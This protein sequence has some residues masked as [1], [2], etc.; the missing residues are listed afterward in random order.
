MKRVTL[1]AVCAATVAL[2]AAGCGSSTPQSSG[3]GGAPGGAKPASASPACAGSSTP[4]SVSGGGTLT[5]WLM[6]GSAPKGWAEQLNAEFAKD[7]PGWK[8]NYQIQEWDGIVAKLNKALSSTSPPDVVELGNTQA[9]SYAE[10]GELAD[11]TS[12]SNEFQCSQWN[13]ALKDSGAFDQKQYAIPFYGANRTVIYRKDMFAKA[14]IKTPPTT[15]AQWIADLG[16]LKAANANDPEFQSLYLPGQEWYTLLSFIWDQGGD[17]AKDKNGTFTATL[18][19]PQAQAG[20]NFYKQLYNASG[21]TAPK[22]TDEANPTQ[23]DVMAKDGGHVAMMIGL[24]WEEAGVATDDPQLANQLGAFPIPS[25]TAGKTAPVFLGGS[26]LGIAANSKNSAAA[27]AYLALLASS[28]YQG[29]LADN[30]S[31]PG[32]STDLTGLSANPV[33]PAMGLASKDGEVTPITPNWATVEAGNNPL[34]T[35]LTAV[36][37]GTKTTQQAVNDADS[38]LNKILQSGN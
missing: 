22:D 26:D 13:Q 9:V 21:T 15:D 31:V 12:M 33:G 8:I 5:V 1:L 2:A 38:Q 30:G 36:L 37:S 18:N 23:G 24:P 3:S 27:Q 11:L 32:T 10:A 34:K 16:K 19:T 28:K 25:H 4:P 29:L 14:G 35:M 17:V 7:H 20:I 6:D